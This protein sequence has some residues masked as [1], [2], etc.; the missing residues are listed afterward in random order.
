MFMLELDTHTTP[1]GH[2]YPM[3]TAEN[4]TRLA[5]AYFAGG[6]ESMTLEMC[7]FLFHAIALDPSSKAFEETQA[8]AHRV[9]ATW[10]MM[11]KHCA[12]A[13]AMRAR[14]E[15]PELFRNALVR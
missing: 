12:M 7:G 14:L 2:Q 9:H 13:V 8:V 10:P 5:A 15:Q 4:R 11:H 1:S 6:D 3:N